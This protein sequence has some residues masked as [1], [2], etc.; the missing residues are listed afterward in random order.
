MVTETGQVKIMDFGLAKLPGGALVTRL[1][2]TLGTVAYMSPEQARGDAVDQRSDLW[3]FGVV[4]YEMLTG[5][6]AVSAPDTSRR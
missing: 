6:L 3:S 2:S 1:G 5:Q 4:L